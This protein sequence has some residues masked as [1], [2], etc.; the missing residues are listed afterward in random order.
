M[1]LFKSNNDACEAF[2]ADEQNRADGLADRI[3]EISSTPG[4]PS[5]GSLPLY[6]EAYRDASTNAAGNTAQPRR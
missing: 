2:A 6:Q 5:T 1:G 3:N 4:H